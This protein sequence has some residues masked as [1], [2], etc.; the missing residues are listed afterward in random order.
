MKWE[1]NRESYVDKDLDRSVHVPVFGLK[2]RRKSR[3]T[4]G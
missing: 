1:D 4:A 3:K 2:D